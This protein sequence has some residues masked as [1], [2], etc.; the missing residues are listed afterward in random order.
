MLKVMLYLLL[1]MH[2]TLLFVICSTLLLWLVTK[3]KKYKTLP[4]L[5][6]IIKLI[7]EGTG[8]QSIFTVLQNMQ[9]PLSIRKPFLLK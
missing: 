1:C 6:L 4:E 3:N 7:Q 8:F 9:E 5:Y 2:C